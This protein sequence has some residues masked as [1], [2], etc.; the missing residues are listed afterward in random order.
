MI[1]FDGSKYDGGFDMQNK[2]GFGRL[3]FNDTSV[4]EGEFSKNQIEGFGRYQYRN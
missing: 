2:H 1:Y 3:Q 4:Y